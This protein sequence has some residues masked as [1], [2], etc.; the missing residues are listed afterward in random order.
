MLGV[1][2]ECWGCL[3]IDR[4]FRMK[5]SRS[6][7]CD[8]LYAGVEAKVDG[9]LREPRIHYCLSLFRISICTSKRSS[10]TFFRPYK[11]SIESSCKTN[12]SPAPFEVKLYMF[13][14]QDQSRLFQKNI[15]VTYT[16]PLV[17][18]IAIGLSLPVLPNCF[19]QTKSPDESKF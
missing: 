11:I 13:Q 18:Y 19:T 16:F 7:G 15:P 8:K 1:K 5:I 9:V 4:D 17:E 3:R 2:C 12:I 14:H 6:V 10:C